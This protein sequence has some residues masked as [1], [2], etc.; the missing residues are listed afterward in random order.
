MGESGISCSGWIDNWDMESYPVAQDFIFLLFFAVL[1]PSVRLFLDRFV[2][3][4]IARRL[5][6]GRKHYELNLEKQ[7]RRKKINKFKESAWKCLYY[8][9]SE[10]F[11][12]YVTYNEPWFTNTRYFWEGPGNQTWPDLKMKMKLKGLYMYAGGFYIYSTFALVFWETRRSDFYV[13]MAHHL[14]SVTLILFSYMLRFAR[15]GS[16]IL[17]IHEGTDVILEIA[18]MAKYSHYEGF[19]SVFLVLFIL[20]FTLL[21]IIYYPF[22]ILWSTRYE[23][24]SVLGEDII[25]VHGVY[26]YLFNTLLFGLF[27]CHIYWWLLMLRMLV[28]KIKTSKLEDDVRSDNEDEEHDD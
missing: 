19:A 24:V 3:E 21:R 15:V 22:W 11:A 23:V 16:L 17:A 25:M 13:T 12:L 27:L 7:W 28:R 18:K 20:S 5:I 10:L 14:A 9:S 6:F 4:G 1:F 8:F 26:Y 2:F